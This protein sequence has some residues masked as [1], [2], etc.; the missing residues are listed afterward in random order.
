MLICIRK[1]WAAAGI[2][3]VNKVVTVILTTCES[4]KNTYLTVASL[5]M[6]FL[7]FIH[8]FIH[9]C[10]PTWIHLEWIYLR[11]ALLSLPKV[12]NILININGFTFS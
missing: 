7:N 6:N 5:Q 12:I 10:S 9:L 4:D 1:D 8:L 11:H 3:N 2:R